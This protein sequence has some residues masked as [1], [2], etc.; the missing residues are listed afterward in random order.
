[1]KLKNK[2]SQDGEVRA[3]EG[4]DKALAKLAVTNKKHVVEVSKAVK[5]IKLKAN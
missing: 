1:L 5:M 2:S 4:K 3:E